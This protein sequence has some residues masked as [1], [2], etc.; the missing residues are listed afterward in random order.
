MSEPSFPSYQLK[1]KRIVVT[2]ASSGIGRAISVELARHGA[3][4]ILVGRNHDRLAETAGKLPSGSFHVLTLDL[5]ETGRIFEEI[6]SLAGSVGRI[7]GLCHSAG[8]VETRPLGLNTVEVT[9][10]M[11]DVNLIAGIELAR[12]ISRRDVIESDGGSLVFI[13]SIYGIVGMP[14]QVSY[15]AS[16]GAV[17]AAVKSMAVELARKNIRVNCISPGYVQ[18]EMTERASMILS[19]DQQQRI[20]AAHPLGIGT[21]EDVA[22]SVAFLLAP[23]NRWITGANLTID[24]GFTAQ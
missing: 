8:T 17:L 12:V 2:G 14:G 7:Y 20:K 4:P 10:S 22:R 16:K 24:G 11:L 18:T 23:V 13:S 3:I 21:P 1:G 6:K 9:Q 19:A 15:S 5:S